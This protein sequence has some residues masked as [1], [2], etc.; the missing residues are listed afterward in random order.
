MRAAAYLFGKSD[1]ANDLIFE[2]SYNK[3]AALFILFFIFK[4]T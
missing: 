2:K 4:D 3:I 1:T